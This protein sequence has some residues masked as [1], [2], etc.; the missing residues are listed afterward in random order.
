V[1]SVQKI[2]LIQ[3][4][5]VHGYINLHPELFFE[6]GRACYR[7]AGGYA[8]LAALVKQIRAANPGRNIFLDNGDTLHGTFPAVNTQG[9]A[10]V[11]IL[12]HLGL[13]A[14]TAHW[15]FAYGPQVFLERA[16]ELEYPVLALNVKKEGSQ[17]RV[18]P[19]WIVKE[20]SGIKVGLI[21][22]A[23]NIVDKTMPPSFHEGLRFELGKA[24]LPQ[25]V[26]ALREREKAHLVV[27]L[28]HL[29]YPQDLQLAA[30]VPGIDVILSGHTHNR[31]AD[32]IR[33]GQTLI[34]QSGS[35]G[36]FLGRLDLLMENGKAAGYD[37]H[38]YE[39]EEAVKPDEEMDELVKNAWHPFEEELSEV[40]GSTISP[41]DRGSSLESTM[42][43]LLL[44]AI[45]EAAGTR[46]AF[47]NGWR[48]G[49]PIL[50]GPVTLNDLHHIIPVNPWISMVEITGQE[51]RQMLEENLEQTFARDPYQQMGGYIKRSSGIQVYFKVENPYPHRIQQLFVEQEKVRPDR[52]YKAAFV[53]EQGVPEKYGRDRKKLDIR[54]VEALRQYLGKH[55]PVQVGLRHTFT[56]V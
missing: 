8:R 18:F 47:S 33:Q 50:P 56:L 42:D 32:P 22:L 26:Q 31:L 4:N 3:V 6:K 25:T 11:P 24:D 21:G 28:S 34:I 15:E 30:D 46:L 53:T 39:V 51:L 48:Y 27:L 17:E 16:E 1:K 37:H 40:V 29:G 12:N 2:T 52:V 19:G 35:H 43:N 14:M 49:G 55:S 44:D 23:S 20:I 10:L 5:D 9:K 7:Q 45:A 38:L 54:A 36:S 41:L 13:D